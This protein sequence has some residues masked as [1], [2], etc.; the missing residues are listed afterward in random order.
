V[1]IEGAAYYKRVLDHDAPQNQDSESSELTCPTVE[2]SQNGNPPEHSPNSDATGVAPSVPIDVADLED[3]VELTLDLVE[4]D[5]GPYWRG[6]YGYGPNCP[7]SAPKLEPDADPNT[8]TWL[9]WLYFLCQDLIL[10]R[11]QLRE[12]DIDGNLRK[13]TKLLAEIAINREQQSEL[14]QKMGK[15]SV[16]EATTAELDRFTQECSDLWSRILCE[17]YG[18]ESRKR[19]HM[20]VA[21]LNKQRVQITSGSGD[22]GQSK[23]EKSG[24]DAATSYAPPSANRV[25]IENSPLL[26]ATPSARSVGVRRPRLKKTKK[27]SR[28]PVVSARQFI[29]KVAVGGAAF[30]LRVGFSK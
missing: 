22:V 28:P 3:E 29:V 4:E 14:R 2:P 24:L 8:S 16:G 27:E 1:S 20:R 11:E 23:G 12:A 18:S 21:E 9:V 10:L 25:P 30:L 6:E 17:P 5:L 26:A 7:E 15:V 13:C 19:L